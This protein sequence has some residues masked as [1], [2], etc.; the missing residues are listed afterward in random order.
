MKKLSYWARDHRTAAR[1]LIIILQLL[2]VLSALYTGTEFRHMELGLEWHFAGIAFTVLLAAAFVY[3]RRLRSRSSS[4][5]RQKICD[6]LIAMSCCCLLCFTINRNYSAVLMPSG[7]YGSLPPEESAKMIKTTV[8]KGP[9]H[10]KPPRK[11]TILKI[12]LI[13]AVVFGSLAC[14]YGIAVLSCSLSCSGSVAMAIAVTIAGLAGVITLA[15]VG[16]RAILRW[17]RRDRLSIRRSRMTGA[18]TLR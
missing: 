6:F 15:I 4:Y 14:L 3:P 10:A 17:A 9:R 18:V 7:V 2:L 12:L 16:I 13:L 1:I 11:R 5:V 8:D